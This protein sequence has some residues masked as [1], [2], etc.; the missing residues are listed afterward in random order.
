MY[1]SPG[2]SPRECVPGTQA[3]LLSLP[4][5]LL[6][7]TMKIRALWLLR[8][9]CSASEMFT[10]KKWQSLNDFGSFNG[11]NYL[12]GLWENA[13]AGS[14]MQ[15]SSRPA[16]SQFLI[17]KSKRQVLLPHCP[18]AGSKEKDQGSGGAPQPS[19]AIMQ[20]EMHLLLC[21]FLSLSTKG[22]R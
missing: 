12:A 21:W 15:T 19:E 6:S 18:F 22:S 10:Q 7:L 5:V 8:C 13:K 2:D 17:A 14:T 4:W 9:L 16:S 20:E 3:L 1:L 11:V